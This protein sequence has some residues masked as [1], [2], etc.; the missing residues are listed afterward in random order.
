[1]D[2]S[3]RDALWRQFGAAIDMLDKSVVACPESLWTERIWPEEPP[4][5]FPRFFAEFWYVAYHTLVWLDLYLTGLPEE[6]FQPPAPFL[7]GE[8]DSPDAA[9]ERPYTREQLRAYLATLRD[10]CRSTMAALTDEEAR[11]PIQYGWTEGQ[12]VTY[13]ELLLYNLR[14]VQGHAAQMSLFLGQRGVQVPA[15]DW[16]TRAL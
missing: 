2:E 12:P 7:N 16:V 8:V 13:L 15:E 1:M 9:P 3:T 6:Q 5:W 4:E 14:H 11:R 10:R